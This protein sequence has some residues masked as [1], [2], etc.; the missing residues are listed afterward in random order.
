SPGAGAQ[1]QNFELQQPQNR[2][3]AMAGETLTLTC[4][5]SG[6][7]PLGPVRWLKSEGSTNQT[8]YDQRAPPPR[9]KRTQN[10]SNTDFTIRISDIHPEDAG[11]YYCVKFR[12]TPIGDELYRRGNGT[13]VS[14]LARP[15]EPAVSGPSRRAVPGQSVPFTCTAGGFYPKD[16]QVRWLRNEV[17]IQTPQPRITPEPSKP[18][19]HMSS[20]VEV[21]LREDDVRSELTCEVQHPTLPSPLRGTYGLGQVLRVPPRVSVVAAPPGAVEMNRTVN[22]TCRVLGFYPGAVNVTWLENGTELS[23]GSTPQPT[24]TPQ[25][26]FELRSSVT[27][28][29]VEEKNGSRLSCWVLHEEQE[30]IS[31]TATLWV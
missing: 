24:E 27:V 16:I 26:L 1:G 6:S 29:A 8:V 9:V 25:G 28:Q 2:V 13:E 10:E 31:S 21:T 18:S 7:G 22:F 14:V 17:P 3:S 30:P 5:A 19:F 15:S 20:T 11:T 23:T 12:K 4:I